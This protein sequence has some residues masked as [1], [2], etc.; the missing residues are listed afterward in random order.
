MDPHPFGKKSSAITAQ[1]ITHKG[2]LKE[3]VWLLGTVVRSRRRVR[4]LSARAARRL[5]EPRG[6]VGGVAA[7]GLGGAVARGG[8]GEF[9]EIVGT[10]WKQTV[11]SLENSSA[12]SK[13][14]YLST[15]YYLISKNLKI[16][17]KYHVILFKDSSK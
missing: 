1:K 3:N 7:E 14:Y 5:A 6:G 10:F 15:M 16:F 11:L 4:R 17:F 2:L 8:R 13:T 12:N 9:R